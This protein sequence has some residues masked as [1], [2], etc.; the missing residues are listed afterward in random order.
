MLLTINTPRSRKNRAAT[1]A[2]AA[3]KERAKQ[4]IRHLHLGE[5]GSDT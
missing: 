5:T 2:L 3:A 1:K 4:L